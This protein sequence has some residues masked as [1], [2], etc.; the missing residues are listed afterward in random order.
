MSQRRTASA[1]LLVGRSIFWILLL[2]GGIAPLGAQGRNLVTTAVDPGQVVPLAGHHPAWANASN[3]STAVDAEQNFEQM[4]M[5]LA[6][7][8][9]QQ[10]AFEELLQ[11]QLDPPSPQYHH[12]RTAAQ[13]GAEFGPSES[14]IQAVTNWLT[15]QGLHVNQLSPDRMILRFGGTAGAIGAA[16]GTDLR[17]Y[18][19]HGGTILG[20]TRMAPATDP[21]IPAALA[22]LVRH[23]RG[24]H[25]PAERP[26]LHTASPVARN[27]SSGALAPLYSSGSIHYLSPLDFD[28]IYDVPTSSYTGAGYTIGIVSWSRVCGE[29]LSNFQSIFGVTF[30]APTEVIPTAYGGVEPGAVENN[31]TCNT[32]ELNGQEEATLDVERAGSTAPG[33]ALLLVASSAAGSDDGIG[34]DTAYLAESSS[35]NILSISFGACEAE[36]T[37]SDVSF[38][39]TLFQTAAGKGISVFVASGDSAAAGCDT[40]FSS[41]GSSSYGDSPNDICASSYATCVGGTE[42]ADSSYST[43]WSTSNSADYASALGYIPEGGWNES[44]TSEVEGSGGGYSTHIGTPSW[45]TGNSVLAAA[46]GRYSPDVAFSA[47]GHDAYLFCMAAA[48]SDCGAGA[49]GSVYGTSAA[50]P[51]MAGVAALLDQK[52]GSSQGNLNPSLYGM[53]ESATIYAAAFHDATP[54]SS[55]VSS[56]TLSTPSMCNNSVYSSTGGAVQ[57]GYALATGYDEVTGLGSLDVAEFVAHYT[58]YTL[59]TV[60]ITPS[61][62]SINT[63]A[64][65][66]ISI[67][68]TSN[69]G[70][71]TGTVKLTSGSYSYSASLSSGAIS[72]TLAAG[73]LSPGSN[74]LTAT[75]TPDSASLG[76]YQG[77]VGSNTVTVSTPTPAVTVT[78]ATNSIFLGSALGVTIRVGNDALTPTGSVTLSSGSYSGTG[79]LS[80]GSVVFTIPAAALAAGADTLLATY[81][82]DSSSSGIFSTS[83]NSAAVTITTYTLTASNVSLSKGATTGNTSTITVAPQYGFEDTVTLTAA[84]SSAP[85]NAV[86]TPT[87]SFGSTSPLSISSTSAA[88]ARLT[89][90]TTAAS[91]ASNHAPATPWQRYAPAGGAVLAGLIFLGIPGRRRTW[92]SLLDL[93][94]LALALGGGLTACGGSSSPKSNATPTTSGTYTITITSI[95]GSY[96]GITST[97]TLTVE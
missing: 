66:Q 46:A 89:I 79:T 65:D 11:E 17:N 32:S 6:R 39:N 58:N 2:A 53:A 94:L 78:P 88:T 31:S 49:L 26:L 19:I 16:F 41:P 22:G 21:T 52:M 55:A 27:A 14:D 84:I 90:T 28:T 67:D 48:A 3:A 57:Q 80:G 43:Y 63:T 83:S 62:S 45:Q 93:L 37:S 33:A 38:W 85:S 12:W 20:E 4:K 61:S 44:S 92:R 95:T 24:L 13:I 10:T 97:M 75:Y 64:S 69:Y 47:A 9:E 15:S 76:T 96:S 23:V 5:V 73:T 60:T 59:P 34:A 1:M 71:P 70:T 77:A 42:F 54:A 25:T 30:A 72:T 87:L 7:P 29:D 8:E 68:V 50:A 18:T 82:P 74:T 40:A 35:A 56:C 36:A 51:S 91:S 81:S 86:G